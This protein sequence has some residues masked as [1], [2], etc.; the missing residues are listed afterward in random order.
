MLSIVALLFVFFLL[1]GVP[2][3]FS[4]GL[5]S[6]PIFIFTDYMPPSIVVQ[7]MVG[8][9]QSY[10][11]MALPFFVIAGN[12]MT[13]AGIATRLVNFSQVLT[14]WMIGGLAQISIVLSLLMGGISGSSVADASMQSRLLGMPMIK[15]GYS[16]GFT[17]AV[18][19]Y[20]SIITA[21]IPPSI[22][23]IVFGFIG[24]VSIGKL[25]IAGIVPGILL[26]IAL[27]ICTHFLAKRKGFEL[28]KKPLP[29]LKDVAKSF[30]E[31]FWALIFPVI[32]V[33]GFRFGFFTATEAG[34]FVIFYALVIGA[35]V[36]KELTVKK[37][38]D[39]LTSS[40]KDIGMIMLIIIMATVLGY[41]ISLEQ[42][43]NA[44]ALALT[45][46]TDNPT[47]T[48]LL[49]L[50]F[51][52]IAGMVMEATVNVLLLTPLFLP[53]LTSLGFDPIHFGVIMITIITLGGSTPPVG[54]TM[55][56]VCGLLNCSPKEY[57]KESVPFLAVI[58][59]VF[60]ILA[61]FPSITLFLPNLLMK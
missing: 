35:F 42:A 18:I 33:V 45:R 38:K 16:K 43:P 9:T 34:A 59:G 44:I 27:M 55:Y 57:I 46:I 4:I 30:I 3:A 50:G 11:L 14:G 19:A 32:L 20:S 49:I 29:K 51:L 53:I 37:L 54:V 40:L 31:S 36:Y 13:S 60:L 61:L 10:P 24:N 21:T 15:K 7:K 17:G 58:L 25:L 8:I 5:A 56:A 39:C 1:T 48:F 52:V 6:I 26:T 23:L 2:V 47:A 28:E 22:G 41:V 12:I